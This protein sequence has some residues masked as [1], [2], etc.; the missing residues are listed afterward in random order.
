MIGLIDCVFCEQTPGERVKWTIACTARVSTR[1]IQ[2]IVLVALTTVTTS[3]RN[4][5]QRPKTPAKQLQQ[6]KLRF[7]FLLSE[8]LKFLSSFGLQI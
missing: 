5:N 2:L 1:R 6:G 4:K 7:V 8:V 3:I